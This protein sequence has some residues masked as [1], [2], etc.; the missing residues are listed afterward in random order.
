MR[1]LP[2][3]LVA[4]LVGT[5]GCSSFGGID[6]GTQPTVTPAPVP[7]GVSH[8]LPYP[9][10]V[11]GSGVTSISELAKAHR[12]GLENRSYTLRE[13]Y[14]ERSTTAEG[15]TSR[16]ENGTTYVSN[17]TRYRTDVERIRTSADGDVHRFHQLAY[18]D[19]SG[20]FTHRPV[21]NVTRRANYSRVGPEQF[22]DETASRLREYL[23]VN[24]STTSR[25]VRNR[26]SY[27]RVVGVGGRPRWSRGPEATLRY[28]VSVL[29]TPAGIV[30]RL[31][32]TYRTERTALR[33]RFRIEDLGNTTVERPSWATG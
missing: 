10:G 20:Q 24:A 13:R 2:A 31:S 12:T 18:R 30:Q 8:P 4:V 6:R 16:R 5:A 14:V 11:D 23:T 27:V 26:T 33:Y 29:L 21:D 22:A 17:A 9:P 7:D 3:L 15:T 1:W 19:A 25:V 32:V 28:R